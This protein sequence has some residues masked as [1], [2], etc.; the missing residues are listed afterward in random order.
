MFSIKHILK[1]PRAVESLR[2]DIITKAIASDFNLELI[3][4]TIIEK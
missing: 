2:K 1:C 4:K 3:Y